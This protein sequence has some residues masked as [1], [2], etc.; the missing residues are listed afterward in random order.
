MYPFGKYTNY[1]G[2]NL[3]FNLYKG[4]NQSR[5]K[6]KKRKKSRKMTGGGFSIFHTDPPAI[7]SVASHCESTCMPQ[8]EKFCKSSCRSAAISALDSKNSGMSRH[9]IET[10]EERIKVLEHENLSLKAENVKYKMREE[11]VAESRRH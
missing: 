1:S 4:G 7:K 8:A 5:K 3:N 2:S 11:F 6:N 10:I 9:L